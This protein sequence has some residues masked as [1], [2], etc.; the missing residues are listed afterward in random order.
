M[1]PEKLLAIAIES[2]K[3]AGI[4]VAKH[5]KQGDYT[6][7]IKADNSPVTSADIAANDVLMDQLKILTY[8]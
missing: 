1:S 3:K 5:Y 4:E 6:A 2:A 8:H 7:E